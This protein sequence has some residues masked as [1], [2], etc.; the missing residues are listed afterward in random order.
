MST[1]ILILKIMWAVVL[2]AVMRDR[3]Y[4][5]WVG[6]RDSEANLSK[7]AWSRYLRSWL[8]A[9]SCDWPEDTSWTVSSS[10]AALSCTSWV[11][12]SDRLHLQIISKPFQTEVSRDR[13]ALCLAG[14]PM[15]RGLL[16]QQ[17]GPSRA[18]LLFI[19]ALT[20]LIL[21]LVLV[22]TLDE[23]DWTD[24]IRMNIDWY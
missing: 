15:L 23:D 5:F 7:A 2:L 9:A 22:A 14:R 19:S 12:R 4:W 3:C 11:L 6:L 13:Q 24:L 20:A 1:V 10:L 21:D 18:L 8:K 17:Q 16:N